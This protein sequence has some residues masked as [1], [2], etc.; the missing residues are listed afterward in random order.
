[1]NNSSEKLPAY[2]EVI[3]KEIAAN[4][5]ALKMS[6][7]DRLPE[8]IN[9]LM[10]YFDN[11]PDE[12][13]Y[14]TEAI[15]FNIS[16]KTSHLENSLKFINKFN[17]CQKQ[18]IYGLVSLLWPDRDNDLLEA[19]LSEDKPARAEE[20]KSTLDK[21]DFLR[22]F[23]RAVPSESW[24]SKQLLKMKKALNLSI[25]DV[26]G[27]VE[28][29]PRILRGLRK[30]PRPIYAWPIPTFLALLT[31][32]F[33]IN[34]LLVSVSFLAYPLMIAVLTMS[35]WIMSTRVYIAPGILYYKKTGLRLRQA[36]KKEW[37][38]S[39]VIE[40]MKKLNI[41]YEQ[42][43]RQKSYQYKT[44]RI[45]LEIRDKRT[46]EGA[47]QFLTSSELIGNCIALRNFVSWCLPSL[48]NDESIMLCDISVK[49]NQRAQL[50]MVAAERQGV[51]V[52]TVNSIEFNNDGAKY[53]E[54]LMPTIVEVLQ[55]V[56]KRSGFKEIYVGISDFGRDWFDSNYSQGQ[57]GTVIKK[58]HSNELGYSYYFDAYKLNGFIYN[59]HYSYMQKRTLI[60]RLYALIFGLI[61]K[62]KGNNEKA[63]AFFDSVKNSHN[64]WQVPTETD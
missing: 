64:F 19:A 43:F 41:D 30:P 23:T 20:M 57:C 45:C 40:Q 8:K 28:M 21:L 51:P 10:S 14:F 3:S 1:M 52:L 32:S 55:D 31:Y 15:L 27:L 34:S 26:M 13:K 53:M 44:E 50:W 48:L 62:L 49:G 4:K 29:R 46:I 37:E 17:P 9:T 35:L 25:E 61:E 63:K 24:N 47:M 6:Y 60:V 12:I 11:A 56:A 39:P 54:M 18:K 7:P 58:I 16:I 59:K 42:F 38:Y 22:K 2:I 5:V 33:A 36:I